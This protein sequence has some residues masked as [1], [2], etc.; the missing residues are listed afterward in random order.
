MPKE[1]MTWAQQLGFHPAL[2]MNGKLLENLARLT[3][4]L[5]SGLWLQHFA[6]SVFSSCPLP[7]LYHWQLD[8]FVLPG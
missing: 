8:I 3:L 7:S 5:R 6:Y 4:M 2:R 1:S